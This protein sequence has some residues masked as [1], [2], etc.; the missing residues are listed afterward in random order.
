[1]N[2]S[3]F[4]DILYSSDKRLEFLQEGQNVATNF[5]Q[6]LEIKRDKENKNDESEHNINE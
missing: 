6:N 4:N 1:M 2:S 5:L 3:V